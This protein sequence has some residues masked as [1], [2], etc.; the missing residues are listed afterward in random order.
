MYRCLLLWCVAALVSNLPPCRGGSL[1]DPD[2]GGGS[3]AVRV[4]G[5]KNEAERLA[6]K[7]GFENRGQVRY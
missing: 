2:A 7:F 5:G 1:S 4:V 6:Q 3:W